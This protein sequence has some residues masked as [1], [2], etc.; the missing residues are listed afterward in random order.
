MLS[1]FET[2][3]FCS[4][5]IMSWD[6]KIGLRILNNSI[7]EKVFDCREV[8]GLKHLVECQDFK[9]LEDFHIFKNF[10]LN[11]NLRFL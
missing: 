5:G 6:K 9:V 8:S 11:K 1:Q 4:N 7:L 10:V 2:W 3:V